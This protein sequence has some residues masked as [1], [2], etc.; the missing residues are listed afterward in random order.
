MLIPDKIDFKTEVITTKK[1]AVILLL[2]IYPKKK[3][4]P[5]TTLKRHVHPYVHC[6]SIY[7]G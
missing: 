3:K 1:G 4:N 7:N 2:G 6:S 5:N